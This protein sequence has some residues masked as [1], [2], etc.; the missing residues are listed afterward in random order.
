MTWHD[1]TR[2][3]ITFIPRKNFRERQGLEGPGQPGLRH[4]GVLGPAAL[5]AAL[6]GFLG[7]CG[8]VADAALS[9]ELTGSTELLIEVRLYHG[10]EVHPLMERDEL[11]VRAWVTLP[12]LATAAGFGRH[13]ALAEG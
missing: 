3:D 11:H 2:R 1:M 8:R 13:G 10:H 12:W 6:A 7:H 9:Q 4:C 5:P